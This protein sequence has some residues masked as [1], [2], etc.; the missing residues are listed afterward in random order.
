MATP[1]H[2]IVLLQETAS[3]STRTFSDF[4]SVS[5]AMNGICQ[6]YEQRLKQMNPGMRNIT[7][8][9]SELY[10]FIDQLGDLCCLVYNGYGAYE[11]HNKQWVK[12]RV[13]AHLKRMAQ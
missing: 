10:A 6:L 9:I 3:K 5:E 12:D 2:T 4:E 7:Y 11:P 8:D 13:F 1:K